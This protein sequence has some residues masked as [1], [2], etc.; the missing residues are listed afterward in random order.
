MTRAASGFIPTVR[1]HSLA[2]EVADKTEISRL[3]DDPNGTA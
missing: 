1:Q 2:D 3:K